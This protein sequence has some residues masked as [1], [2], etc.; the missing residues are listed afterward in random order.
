LASDSSAKYKTQSYQL[1][2][3]AGESYKQEDVQVAIDH[4]DNRVEIEGQFCPLAP[5][6]TKVVFLVDFSLSMYDAKKD[7]GNDPVKDGSCGRLEAVQAIMD[8][9]SNLFLDPNV[10]AQ[11]GMI[12]FSKDIPKTVPLGSPEDFKDHLNADGMCGGTVGGTNYKE[13]F[14]EATKMLKGTSG[15]KIIYFISDGLP[16]I[17]GDK[18]LGHYEEH[19][20]AGLKA[21][22]ELNSIEKLTFNTLFLGNEFEAAT[23]P[24]EYLDELTPDK[25]RIKF[26]SK[27]EELAEGILDLEKPPVSLKESTV[28]GVHVAGDKKENVG[29]L[30]FES[31]EDQTWRFRTAVFQPFPNEETESQFYLSVE[32]DSGDEYRLTLTLELQE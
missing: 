7:V 22:E 16:T 31:A 17:G 9:H 26:V 25:S 13:A 19:R 18:E 10:D 2:C 4:Q 12:A 30:T 14:E 29:I 28:K 21:A 5:A 6:E 20:D 11:V 23:D 1:S 15:A 27:A 8:K 24:E 3:S 32:D